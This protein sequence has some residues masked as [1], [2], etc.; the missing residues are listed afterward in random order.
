VRYFIRLMEQM[1]SAIAVH[2]FA[3]FRARFF[4]AYAVSSTP[5]RTS[6]VD[7]SPTGRPEVQ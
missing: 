2:E 5:D 7:R 4:S 1:R 6:E 3:A